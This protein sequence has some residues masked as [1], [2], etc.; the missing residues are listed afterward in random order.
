MKPHAHCCTRVLRKSLAPLCALLGL[1][2][3]GSVLTATAQTQG[4]QH[5]PP[6]NKAPEVRAGV[7]AAG[8]MPEANI[9]KLLEARI[10]GR[11]ARGLSVA[12]IEA[13]GTVRYL[14]A[15]SSGNAAREAID[16]D[17]IFEIGSITKTFTGTLLAQ[18][19]EEGRL[20]PDATVRD[21]ATRALPKVKL[22]PGGAGDI[23]LEALATHTSGMPRL[24]GSIRFYTNMLA[25]P[26]NPYKGY[27]REDLW[28]YLSDYK[29]DAGK[30]H[31]AAYSNLGMGLLGDLLALQEG[32]DF[33]SLVQRRI[34]LPLGLKDTAQDTPAA[35]RNRL[36]VGHDAKLKPVS[37]W[38]LA[39]LTG[40]GGLRS[41]AR[42]MALYIK[43]QQSGSLA[44]ARNA[45]QPRAK[46]GEYSQVGLAWITTRRHGDEIVWHNGGTGG[47]RSFAGF[48]KLSGRGVVVLANSA[49]EQDDLAMHLLNP[50]S[51]LK[52]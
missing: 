21:I 29:H 16:A 15:G 17:T 45:Q 47:F 37:Y 4:A 6:A 32:T 50:A 31:A 52:P 20:K 24:P 8:F 40:A 46:M 42:D 34:A 22:P 30:T 48:S 11:S 25:Q 13:D 49:H 44:G 36:A 51:P 19:Q 3:Q 14:S 2:G 43:S 12:L 26:D 5:M 39:A 18:L 7:P 38:D 28:S 10:E 33:N 23:R 35:A 41:S 27:S 9:R 1:I